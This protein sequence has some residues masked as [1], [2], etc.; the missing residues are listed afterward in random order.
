MI[1]QEYTAKDTNNRSRVYVEVECDHCKGTYVRQKRQLNNLHGCSA[2]CLSHL[3]GTRT[4]VICS[5]CGIKH[6]KKKSSLGNSK[7]GLYFCSRA[8]HNAGATYIKEV[9][10]DHYGTGANYRAKALKEFGPICNRCG[11]DDIRAI[12]VH[13][14]DRDR[15]NNE[16]S[17]LEVLC[18]NCHSIEHKTQRGMLR[19][20]TKPL[21]GI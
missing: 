12:E 15:N 4:V 1:L 18:A 8:C 3:K 21:Q 17:N 5:H 13:H 20:S 10:P 9:M 19:A 14:K 2:K 11:F 7:S 6:D 16:L